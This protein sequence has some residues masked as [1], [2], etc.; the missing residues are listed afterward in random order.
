MY[1][2]TDLSWPSLDDWDRERQNS[3]ALFPGS[4]QNQHPERSFVGWSISFSPFGTPPNPVTRNFRIQVNLFH[5]LA[6]PFH[7]LNVA[8]KDVV[9]PIYHTLV[10]PGAYF[11]SRELFALPSRRR[12]LQSYSKKGTKV[13]G[14]IYCYT[15]QRLKRSYKVVEFT[16]ESVEY[17]FAICDVASLYKREPLIKCGETIELVCLSEHEDAVYF[18]TYAQLEIEIQKSKYDKKKSIR[19]LLIGSL[20]FPLGSF[21]FLLC[22][23]LPVVMLPDFAINK[24]RRCKVCNV[25]EQD[26]AGQEQVQ[27]SLHRLVILGW[28]M[29]MTFEMT[30]VATRLNIR[31]CPEECALKKHVEERRLD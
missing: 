22:I 1:L 25:L 15:S 7:L 2:T 13:E 3:V 20:F 17:A 14:L 12:L 6:Y 4:I 31:N 5:L 8:L 24:D 11:L 27:H 29:L 10:F 16:L 26:L 28:V 23:L 30:T 18:F 21:V 19:S 9:A